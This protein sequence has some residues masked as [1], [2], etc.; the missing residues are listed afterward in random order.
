ML[1]DTPKNKPFTMINDNKSFSTPVAHSTTWDPR[2]PLQNRTPINLIDPCV[3]DPSLV[4]LESSCS[5]KSN[6]STLTPEIDFSVYNPLIDPRSPVYNGNR[7]PIQHAQLVTSSSTKKEK[8]KNS[9]IQ[10][11]EVEIPKEIIQKVEEPPK[12]HEIVI[13]KEEEQDTNNENEVVFVKNKW[14]KMDKKLKIKSGE[15]IL[16]PDKTFKNI[17]GEGLKLKEVNNNLP[18][19]VG[20]IQKPIKRHIA[21]HEKTNII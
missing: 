1:S 13:K 4:S 18:K 9:I 11:T 20:I 19:K 10:T 3:E 8:K 12:N 21:F 16:I 5:L 17:L 15:E 6:N 2:S 14:I 7:T